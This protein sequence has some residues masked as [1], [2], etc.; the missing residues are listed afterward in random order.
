MDTESVITPMSIAVATKESA[1]EEN[2]KNNDA[3]VVDI[4]EETRDVYQQ[5]NKWL[6]SVQSKIMESL[7]VCPWILHQPWKTGNSVVD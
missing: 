5:L 4:I 6:V 2:E 7:L 1:E 3:E